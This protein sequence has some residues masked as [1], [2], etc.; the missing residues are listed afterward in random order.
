MISLK[1]TE[2]AG[3]IETE[4]EFET[5]QY[6]EGST[7]KLFQDALNKL[8]VKQLPAAGDQLMVEAKVTIV[9]SHQVDG[10][11][12]VDLQIT[13]IDLEVD[14]DEVDEG[15]LTRGESKAMQALAAKLKKM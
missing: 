12:W 9:G 4:D 2:P 5:S 6:P 3:E 15:E 11:F 13:D 1:N 8:G 14:G 10:K 7:F